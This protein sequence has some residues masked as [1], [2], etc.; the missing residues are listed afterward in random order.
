MTIHSQLELI[1]NAV[2]GGSVDIEKSVDR[3]LEK[4]QNG[5]HQAIW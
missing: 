5:E 3:I 4:L 2:A 1:A